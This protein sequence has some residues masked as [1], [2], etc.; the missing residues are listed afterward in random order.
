MGNGSPEDGPLH[1]SAALTALTKLK[2]AGPLIYAAVL[3]ACL[4]LLFLPRYFITE[5]GLDT[6]VKS[7]RMYVGVGVLASASLL[8]A[9]LIVFIANFVS[10][11]L[12][13]WRLDKIWLKTL[14]ELTEAEKEF[15]RPYIASGQNTQYASISDGVPQG[16]QAKHLI[17]RASTLSI[18]GGLFPYNLQPYARRLLKEHPH[19]LE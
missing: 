13:A 2:D 14:A 5:L 15:L 19:L 7:Y 16:L 11:P 1:W 17:F 10:E 18:P 9:H 12:A 3:I 4:L 8:S 6:F